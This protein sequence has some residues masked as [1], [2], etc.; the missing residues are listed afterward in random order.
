MHR[1]K[2]TALKVLSWLRSKAKNDADDAPFADAWRLDGTGAPQSLE[3]A[4][5]RDA[6]PAPRARPERAPA[7]FIEARP[8]QELRPA[9]TRPT[10]RCMALCLRWWC[11]AGDFRNIPA[12]IKL[13]QI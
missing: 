2:E 9:A 3:R 10:L 1:S 4:A 5:A 12:L 8:V 7:P 6:R 11:V 13:S